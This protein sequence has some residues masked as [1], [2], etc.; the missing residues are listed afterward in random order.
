[1]GGMETHLQSLCQG[2]V[3][4]YNVR[5]LVSSG[6]GCARN[7]EID[8]IRLSRLPTPLTLF[9]T[10]ICPSMTS[11]IR[12]AKADIV[13]IHLPNPAAVAA[14]LASGYRG[15]VIFTYHSDTVRQR[16][17]GAM[18]EPM[19]HTAL[20]RSSAIIATSP[21]YVRTSSVLSRYHDRC[22]IIPLGIAV[23]D[24]TRCAPEMAAAV[25]RQYGD[26]LI[27][28]VGRLV[29]YKG[30][31]YL[32]RAM[33]RVRGTL[34][35]IGEGPLLGTLSKLTSELGMADRV[36][37]LGG[38]DQEYLVSCYHASD[39]FVLASVARSEAFGIV[40]IEAMAAGLPVVNTRLDSGVPYVSVHSQT[41]LTVP[42]ADPEALAS[43]INKLLD[44]E[45]LRRRLGAAGQLRA[46]QE[47][48]L[49][50]M[51]RRT[52]KLYEAVMERPS[53]TPVS[54]LST[55]YSNPAVIL[56]TTSV[57]P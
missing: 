4:S 57:S 55:G 12:K 14:Y 1:M 27:V 9:S 33:T 5:V 26:R 28:S 49:E 37:F 43:A 51:V 39:A 35:I 40:Q 6:Q 46:R 11:E 48:S 2:L 3:E 20:R 38:V 31:E 36:H 7:E 53:G 45:G 29:Y 42:P 54:G 22:Q 32:I 10:P 56:Q 16:V 52:R 8:G 41:G 23:E 44:D 34:L 30:L 18:V 19:L 21:D 15:R 25:R 47:F 24:F 13:H 17:L 50:T